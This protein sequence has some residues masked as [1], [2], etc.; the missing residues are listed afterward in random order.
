MKTELI[1][2]S[3]S[4]RIPSN[5]SQFEDDCNSPVLW[6]V[7]QLWGPV[8]CMWIMLLSVAGTLLGT[9]QFLDTLLSAIL[10]RLLLHF[11]RQCCCYYWWDDDDVGILRFRMLIAT[12]QDG[13]STSTFIDDDDDCFWALT[14][15]R[16]GDCVWDFFDWEL[17][18]QFHLDGRWSLVLM[19]M[20][21]VT[22]HK[23]VAD[24]SES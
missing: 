21:N 14:T 9:F 8:M 1:S 20:V 23:H 6:F 7:L 3:I 19:I 10:I 24:P 12:A 11:H 5:K 16:D 4:S 18:V 13:I 2:N 22:W 17:A 15:A